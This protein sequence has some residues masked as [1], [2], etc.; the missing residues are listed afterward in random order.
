MNADTGAAPLASR[1]VANEERSLALLEWCADQYAS[2]PARLDAERAIARYLGAT[3]NADGSV[4]FGFWVPELL[5]HRVPDGDVFLE[6]LAPHGDL[7][8]ER[9]QQTVDFQRVLLPLERYETLAFVVVDGLHVGTRDQVGDFYALS[10]RDA[11]GKEHRICD[12]LAAST[13]FG[14]FAPAEIIDTQ[15]IHKDRADQAYYD[16][17]KGAGGE[18]LHK[19]GPPTNILQVH[20]PTATAGGTLASL[21]RHFE[22]I[23]GRLR[24]GL[25]DR[26][27]VV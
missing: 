2:Q 20:V 3:A 9:S 16:G 23:A 10:W 7:D 14:A 18:A 5:D 27:S 13:P 6:L 25:P 26:K 1:A 22:R 11:D 21:A 17:L 19:F 4:T 15:D 12:P 24:H 8:L